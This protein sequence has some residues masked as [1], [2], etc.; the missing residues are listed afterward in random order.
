MTVGVREQKVDPSRH[1][2]P[3]PCFGII[4]QGLGECPLLQT[5]G[6]F[7]STRVP[8][9]ARLLTKPRPKSA[10]FSSPFGGP[11]AS[12]GFTA[13]GGQKGRQGKD[14]KRSSGILDDP[15]F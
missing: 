2:F 12:S 1:D 13:R 9:C 3:S 6:V 4:V 10:P 14:V 15:L 8:S 5:K 11:P 7:R